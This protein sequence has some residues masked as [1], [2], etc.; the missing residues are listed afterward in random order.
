MDST[1]I[2]PFH[3]LAYNRC[4]DPDC[5]P[6][7]QFAYEITLIRAVAEPGCVALLG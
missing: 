4:G 7:G 6:I 3:A 2:L 5:N 1:Q